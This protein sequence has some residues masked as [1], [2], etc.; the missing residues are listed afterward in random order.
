M[1]ATLQVVT[2]GPGFQMALQPDGS[3]V[4]TNQNV[5]AT[6]NNVV[7][8]YTTGMPFVSANGN[9]GGLLWSITQG[10]SDGSSPNSLRVYRAA[11][12]SIVQA[13]TLPDRIEKFSSPIVTGGRCLF[14][15]YTGAVY[16]FGLQA[17]QPGGGGDT[18]SITLSAFPAPGTLDPVRS[19]ALSVVTNV[20]YVP[21]A[22]RVAIVVID[23]IS[24]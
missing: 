18:G 16:G 12:F 4:I 23:Y 8:G 11:D 14:G 3:L 17:G 15:T 20:A 9:A 24:L 13:V 1:A 22:G 2:N 5:E 10:P 7:F 21:F 19:A 6:A